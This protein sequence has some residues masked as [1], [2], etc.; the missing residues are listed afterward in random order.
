MSRKFKKAQRKKTIEQYKLEHPPTYTEGH[1]DD[2][3]L[4]NNSYYDI[5][6]LH[7]HN[8]PIYKRI[9]LWEKRYNEASSWLG[10]WYC[11]IR[12]DKERVKL[13]YYENKS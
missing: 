3:M 12:I 8:K 9:E 11:Q 5:D 6:L 10:K 1:W 13:K 7:K 4:E 2:V